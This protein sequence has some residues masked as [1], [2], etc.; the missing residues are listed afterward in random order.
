MDHHLGAV[1]QPAERL[2]VREVAVD[3]LEIVFGKLRMVAGAAGQNAN[4]PTRGDQCRDDI[5][6][7]KSGRPGDR[8]EPVCRRK[9]LGWAGQSAAGAACGAKAGVARSWLGE[10]LS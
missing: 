5:A 10:D 6:A 2:A 7:Q 3:R 1:D 4:P 9:V 8:R